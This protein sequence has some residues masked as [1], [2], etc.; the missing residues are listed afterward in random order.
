MKD[1][2]TILFGI[3]NDE[4][5][6]FMSHMYDLYAKSEKTA[7][8]MYSRFL[9]PGQRLMCE[10]RFAP[11]CNVSFFGGYDGAERVMASFG[12][13]GT[14]EENYPLCGVRIETKGVKELT[15]RD[16]LGSLLSLGISRELVGDIIIEGK[17][18][19]VFACEDIADFLTMNLN[20]VGRAPASLSVLYDLSDIQVQREFKETYATVSSLRLDAVLAAAFHRSR[21]ECA[22][23]IEEGLANVNYSVQKS[24]SY[25]VKDGDIISLRSYGKFELSTDRSLTKKG[26]ISVIIKK[27]GG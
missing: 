2:K 13:S 11:F 18:A 6:S 26:R 20:R 12:S 15:H 16:F 23:L 8:T 19:I 22:R 14:P 7:R 25:P 24:V 3:T 1:K 27:Y 17:T 5:R 10:T 9:S 4:D 21:S